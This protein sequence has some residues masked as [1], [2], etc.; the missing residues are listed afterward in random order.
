MYVWFFAH[1]GI[2]FVSSVFEKADS[3]GLSII[4]LFVPGILF[5][6]YANSLYHNSI[7]KKIAVAQL[8]IKE[9][10][11]LMEY[12]RY[13]GGVHEWVIWVFGWGF[14]GMI[15][16]IFLIAIFVP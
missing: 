14:V 5:S 1:L 4:I 6:I 9:E 15:V 11:K 3:S 7:K 13:K 10:A 2:V 16:I 8:S 12:L